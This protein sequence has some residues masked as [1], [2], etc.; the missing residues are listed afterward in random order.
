M[1]LAN[2]NSV[3]ITAGYYKIDGTKASLYTK[4][5]EEKQA[6]E[7]P[8]FV[9]NLIEDSKRGNASR[10]YETKKLVNGK[11]RTM[12]IEIIKGYRLVKYRFN[13]GG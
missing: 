8:S 7:I 12:E 9:A 4:H 10:I 2:D 11:R 3:K 13:Y 1:R 6:D 5:T